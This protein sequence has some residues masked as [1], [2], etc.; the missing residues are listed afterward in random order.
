MKI[1][2]VLVRIMDDGT[3]YFEHGCFSYDDAM[4]GCEIAYQ[5]SKGVFDSEEGMFKVI[6]IEQA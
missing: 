6:N 3:Y 2:F 5:M 4:V 1:T